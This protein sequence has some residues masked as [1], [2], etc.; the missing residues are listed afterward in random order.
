MGCS[1]R[2]IPEPV[3]VLPPDDT[4][5]NAAARAFQIGEPMEGCNHHV[6]APE[7]ARTE[8]IDLVPVFMVVQ[9]AKHLLRPSG[10]V[11]RPIGFLGKV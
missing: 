5:L 1:S 4:A 2:N 10:G 8:Q 11:K 6:S 9:K 7:T 3:P